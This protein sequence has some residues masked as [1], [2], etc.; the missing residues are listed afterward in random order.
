MRHVEQRIVGVERRAEFV[1]AGKL[2]MTMMMTKH[3]V[4]A[5]ASAAVKPR[6]SAGL[7]VVANSQRYRAV[8]TSSVGRIVAGNLLHSALAV[9]TRQ[10]VT[11]QI[12][13]GCRFVRTSRLT[14]LIYSIGPSALP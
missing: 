4:T 11:S 8:T 3:D 5:A 12:P 2:M 13:D 7:S 9:S 10:R 14:A 6:S 1:I